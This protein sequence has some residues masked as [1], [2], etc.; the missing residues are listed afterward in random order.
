MRAATYSLNKEI[1]FAL[2][3]ARLTIA[4]TKVLVLDRDIRESGC[5]TL[6]IIA[7]S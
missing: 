2:S 1:I 4:L 6:S 3:F 5:L 7:S